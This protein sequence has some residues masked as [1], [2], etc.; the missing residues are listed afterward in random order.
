ML[1][2]LN[3]VILERKINRRASGKILQEGRLASC[4][5]IVDDFE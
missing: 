5:L 1:F 3:N 2:G 4:D